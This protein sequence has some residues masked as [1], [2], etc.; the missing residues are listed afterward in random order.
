MGVGEGEGSWRL[1]FSSAL[2]LD[3]LAYVRTGAGFLTRMH[4]VAHRDAQAVRVPTFNPASNYRQVSVLRLVNPS[5]D[6]RGV[7]ITGVDVDGA[8]PGSTV[9][10]SVPPRGART[11]T[12]AELESGTAEGLSGMLGDG[13]GKWQLTVEPDGPLRA[14]SL[15]RSPTGH[16]TNLSTMPDRFPSRWMAAQ[17]ASDP[18]AAAT[19]APSDAELVPLTVKKADVAVG[20]ESNVI[21]VDTET[22]G[23]IHFDLGTLPSGRHRSLERTKGLLRETAD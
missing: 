6:V 23:R 16:L 17:A 10:L 14:L 22:M 8:S 9:R 1:E 21:V 13:N 11:L 15:L 12:S 4:D 3:V 5:D 20:I 19:S 2:D 18:G 7:A